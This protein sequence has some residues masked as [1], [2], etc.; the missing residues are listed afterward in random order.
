MS[1]DSPTIT[2]LSV[3]R[4]KNQNSQYLTIGFTENQNTPCQFPV[5]EIN[6]SLMHFWKIWEQCYTIGGG[7]G[8]IKIS[9]IRANY[10]CFCFYNDTN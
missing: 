2:A 6:P 1:Y 10:E 7:G 4:A 9:L 8:M 5:L 3:H